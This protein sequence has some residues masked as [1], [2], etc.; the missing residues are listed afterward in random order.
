MELSQRS[1]GFASRPLPRVLLDLHDE[2]VTGR[3]SLR[4][5]GIV[6][7]VDLQLGDP[8]H[9]SSTLREE[10]L[11]HFLVR[12]GIIHEAQHQEAVRRAAHSKARLGEALVNMGVLHQEQLIDQLARQNRH[13]LVAALRWSQGGWR[14]DVSSVGAVAAVRLP[15]VELVL[16]GLRDSGQ[17]DIDRLR[18]FDGASVELAARGHKLHVELRA[19]FG[20]A[21]AEALMRGGPVAG[22]ERACG[23]RFAARNALDTL[24][25]CGALSWTHDPRAL[26]GAGPERPAP[27]SVR[28]GPIE[29]KSPAVG[30]G[31][32]SLPRGVAPRRSEPSIL[33][34]SLSPSDSRSAPALTTAVTPAPSQPASTV[35]RTA[36]RANIIP[37]LRNAAP[38]AALP[39]DSAA[40]ARS[41]PDRIDS[42][43]ALTRREVWAPRTRTDEQAAFQPRTVTHEAH[44]R[45]VTP[46]PQ[47][48]RTATNALYEL[49][50]EDAPQVRDGATPLALT[51]P[52]SGI[53]SINEVET[54]NED[55][56]EAMRARNALVAEAQRIRS[57]N[58]Y[59]VLMVDRNA[60]QQQLAAAI[61]ERQRAFS[62][63]AY[64]RLALGAD[65]PRLDEVLAVYSAARETLL[66]PEARRRYD[67]AL[68]GD[69]TTAAYT[70]DSELSYRDAED[71]L[72][73]QRFSEAIALLETLIAHAPAQADFHASLGW[74]HWLHRGPSISAGDAAIPHLR[75]ALEIDPEHESAHVHLASI[76]AQLGRDDAELLFHLERAL[77][78]QPMR[79]DAVDLLEPILLRRGELRRLERIYKRLLFR[80]S[81]N[82]RSR[83]AEIWLKLAQLYADHL[84]DYQ[85]AAIA[86]GNAEAL[87]PRHPIIAEIGRD[88][89]ATIL[90]P[91]RPLEAE[92]AR[93]RTT[94]DLEAATALIRSADKLGNHDVA[95]LTAATMVAL[96]NADGAMTQIY[97]RDRRRRVIFPEQPLAESHWALLRHGDDIAD[98]GMLLDVVAPA[99]HQLAPINLREAGVDASMRVAD[100]EL[101]PA[102]AHVRERLARLYGVA[103]SAVY[104]RP[105][106]ERHVLLVACDPPVLVAGDDALTAPLRPEL[107]CRLARAMSHARPGRAVGGS[108]SG[109]VL[110]AIV[111][112]VIREASSST[113]GAQDPGAAQADAALDV[114]SVDA[115]G[116]ARAAA[117]RL[118]ARGGGFN[119]SIWGRSLPRTADRVALL[120]CGD[121]PTALAIA[122]ENGAVERDLVEFAFSAQHVALRAALRLSIAD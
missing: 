31:E 104:A 20:T 118:L 93:L 107:V 95:F 19:I 77:E 58:L 24:D 57:A 18:R 115:R 61:S 79:S 33:R 71:L 108:R 83:A 80:L 29:V 26:P 39:Q 65:R 45:T 73:R 116:H 72:A 13:K 100:H 49:L 78:L 97:Q 68:T 10:T 119:L 1:G 89:R 96:G 28:G 81:S 75:H 114:L 105:E 55:S 12:T 99:V 117:L 102:F 52:D 122:R 46:S 54:A 84:D 109:T 87:A 92:R 74:A 76:S 88:L 4:H 34:P 35:S 94:R 48:A 98:L 47:P 36:A 82:F 59:T 16:C 66:D 2:S 17:T 69:D 50:F 60:D 91:Q 43:R 67:R 53:V 110:R 15:M 42:S 111:L 56:E 113:I 86:L 101:P 63:D 37:S 7:I 64:A 25:L 41:D 27:V 30:Q 23:D 38:V 44:S 21:V 9:V 6:K 121:I 90:A 40:P 62:H 120:L 112:A 106:I 70:M 22:I 11:G 3:L 85:A 14:F 32:A 103:P 8:V 51:D 5:A